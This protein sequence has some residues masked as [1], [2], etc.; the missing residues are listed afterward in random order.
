MAT[1]KDVAERSGISIKT[2][3]RVINGAPSVR[4][5]VRAKVEQAIRDL[6][7]RPALAARQ[8]ATGRSF[9]VAMIAP[10]LTFSYFAGLMVA[11]AS[12][13]RAAG[14]HLV[15]EVV[16][17]AEF[18]QQDQWQLQLSCEPDAVIV[19]PPFSDDPRMIEALCALGKP[20]VRIAGKNDGI[21]H[22]VEVHD[23]AIAREMAAYLVGKGHT[24]LAM[25]APPHSQMA[26]EERLDGFRDGL[27]EHGIE[28]AASCIVRGTMRF[29]SGVAA[30][31]E[32]MAL[33][34]RPT[35]IF[36]ANDVMA[37]GAM[38]TALRLGFRVPQDIAIAGFDNAAEGQMCFP[39]LTSIHQPIEEI[40]EAAVNLALGRGHGAGSFHHRLI[41]RESA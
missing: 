30:F 9:I 39:T 18:S 8:L 33:P 15:L 31:K 25:I 28:L 36:A 14:H 37:L 34:Q 4:A 20:L 3:S 1:I 19:V 40:A 41:I 22:S 38:S 29:E 27:A 6:N 12:A 16:D 7:Y 35:A 26:A 23:H 32:L 13:C 11:S 2:V 21:G 10:R 17:A 24:R 5:N